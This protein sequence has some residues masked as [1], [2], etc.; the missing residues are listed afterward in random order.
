MRSVQI[1]I[2]PTAM[3]MQWEMHEDRHIKTIE[4]QNRQK[5]LKALVSSK[6]KLALA[7]ENIFQ[8]QKNCKSL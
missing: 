1:F 4:K 5:L 7:L 6:N 2:E 8:C 3:F